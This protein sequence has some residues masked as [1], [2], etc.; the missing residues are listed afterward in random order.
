MKPSVNKL[1]TTQDEIDKV[2]SWLD[3]RRLEKSTTTSAVVNC[4]AQAW[5]ANQRLKILN[6]QTAK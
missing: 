6:P 4:Q 3:K 5:L 2:Q 1:A